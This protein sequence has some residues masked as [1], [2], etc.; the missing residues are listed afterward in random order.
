MCDR[1]PSPEEIQQQT[2]DLRTNWDELEYWC[3]RYGLSRN[4]AADVN[5]VHLD[6]VSMLYCG[7][8]L[9]RVKSAVLTE[10]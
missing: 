3:R 7:L 5:A 2:A 6:V 4:T 8:P 1:C 10:L 9:R